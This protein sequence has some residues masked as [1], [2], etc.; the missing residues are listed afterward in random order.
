MLKKHSRFFDVCLW[1][2]L[3]T[4]KCLIRASWKWAYW[5]WL[6]KCYHATIFSLHR[7]EL[8]ASITLRLMCSTNPTWSWHICQTWTSAA[9]P[10]FLTCAALLL[11]SLWS[12]VLVY[13]SKD[14][15][16]LLYFH[17]CY[18]FPK[19]SFNGIIEPF[20]MEQEFNGHTVQLP[21]N[22]QGYLQLD[23]VAWPWM[24]PRMGYPLPLWASC[25]SVTPPL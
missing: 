11:I 25:F 15:H 12:L 9:V 21:C 2:M 4:F 16:K 8:Q 13:F 24:S 17:F 7:T 23:K 22:V 19:I 14:L 1:S 5:T 3:S 6:N 18:T 20:E 10:A